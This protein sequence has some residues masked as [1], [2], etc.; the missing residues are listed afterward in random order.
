MREEEIIKLLL[1]K[2]V[3]EEELLKSK[4]DELQGKGL[5][6]ISGDKIIGI[7]ETMEELRRELEEKGEDPSLVTIDTVPSRDVSFIL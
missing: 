7:A 5:I 1:E 6:A 3:K 2:G 4:Y